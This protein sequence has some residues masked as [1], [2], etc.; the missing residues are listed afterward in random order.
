MQYTLS[1]LAVLTDSQLIG[2]PG[3]PI[4]GVEN[5]EAASFHEAAF[6]ENARYEKQL[7]ASR[8]GA[9]FIQPSITPLPGRNFLITPHPSLA[10]QKVLELFIATPK[11]GFTGI[12]PS[13]V[14]HPE[15]QVGEGTEIGPYAVIDRGAKIEK[16]CRIG[17]GVFIGAE[18]QIGTEC[19]LHAKA[20]IRE[21]CIIGNRVILQ[22]GVVIGSCGFGY[23]TDGKGK[24][25]H[26]RQLG[27]VIIEDD[28]EIGANT[29]I[30]R[31]RF[32]TTRIS[33]GTK[34]DNL[35]QIGH[36]VELG[37]DNL[38]VAQV[39][40]AGSTKTGHHVVMGG[41]VGVAGHL[42]IADGVM[43]AA[44]SGVTKSLL[45]PGTY[46]GAPAAP[47]KEV[48][49]QL[50][51]MRSMPKLLERLKELENKVAVLENRESP[52]K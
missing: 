22:P 33:R 26:L 13:A 49:T 7:S 28:V 3:H 50:V 41:Q 35:V 27:N 38:I 24:H 51:H 37:A 6:L 9:V 11:S 12:H 48:A 25:I 36:Q 5:L 20:V 4:T 32:K 29:T 8:A 14:I 45:E 2:H 19:I 30:D 34:I 42:V 10:F 1:E 21:G 31:A 40:I 44:K 16:N 39:G 23:F 52:C 15:A 43:L 47:M 46:G 18:T 17:A